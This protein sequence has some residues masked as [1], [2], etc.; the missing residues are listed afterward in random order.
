MNANEPAYPQ[1]ETAAGNPVVSEYGSIACGL[2]KR[3]HCVIEMAKAIASNTQAREAA[4]KGA[5]EIGISE[6]AFMAK[7]A[8]ELTDA[9]FAELANP[10]PTEPTDGK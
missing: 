1:P 8:I 10:T 6:G 7:A 5:K 4:Y 3:E 9:I 2:T